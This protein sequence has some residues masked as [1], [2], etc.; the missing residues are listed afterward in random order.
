MTARARSP[1]V[2]PL[3]PERWP[4]LEK[5]FGPSGADGGC[6]CMWFRLRRRDFDKNTGKE[7]RQA[8]KRL[9]DSG[10]PPGLLGYVGG[11]PVG[12]VSLAPR[13]GF[14]H[15]EHSRKLRRVDERPVWSIVCFVVAKSHRGQGLMTN[16]LSAALDFARDRGATIVEAY[17]VEAKG[18]LT[19]YAGYTGIAS[20]FRKAG[21]VE[22]ARA[23][24]HQPIMRCFMGDGPEE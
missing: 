1:E 12:W 16:L 20:A 9:V 5:L 17:P 4:D 10:E 6:W 7:N 15:L 23:S 22:V 2:H 8:L 11:E 19:G 24:E 14:A 18:R 21:F 3:T 13:E